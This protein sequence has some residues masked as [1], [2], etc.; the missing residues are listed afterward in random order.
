MKLYP[1]VDLERNNRGRFKNRVFGLE[2]PGSSD[3]VGSVTLESGV[4]RRVALEVKMPGEKP[5]KEQQRYIDKVNA[6]GGFACV[7]RSIDEAVLAVHE[8]RKVP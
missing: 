8:A 2:E 3:F 4:A 7:V 1:W 5:T 6:L